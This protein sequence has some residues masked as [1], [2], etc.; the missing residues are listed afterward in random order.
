MSDQYD[1]VVVG[2]GPGGY[3][4]AI[5]AAQYGL[6]TAIVE[7]DLIGGT[8]LN[9]G[10]IPTKA[11]LHMGE[12]L[13]HIN[14]AK[15]VGI[16]VGEPQVDLAK[17]YA[18]K[19]KT[20]KKLRGG[21]SSLLKANKVDVHT[22]TGVLKS[23]GTVLVEADGKSTTLKCKNVILATG[24]KPAVPPIPGLKETA[25]WTSK[26]M[27]ETNPEL[28]KSMIIIGGG[29][30]GAESATILSD[31]GVEVTIVEMMDQLLPRMDAEV[32]EVLR[33]SL[34]KSGVAI[35]LGV[36]VTEVGSKAGK[37][38]CR[39]ETSAGEK[40]VEAEEV[41][42]AVGRRTVVDAAG[43]EAA[44]VKLDRGRV[45]VDEKMRTNLAGVYAIG[46]VTG[47]WW[48]A[49]AASAEGLA[50]VD[51]I[52][53]KANYTNRSVMPACVY[54]R[55]E[56]AAVGAT[57]EEAKSSGRDVRVGRFPISVNSKSMI[58]G[59]TQGFVKI[60]A[61]HE[62]GE[63]LG[64]HLVGPRATDMISEIA[65]AMSAELTI[66]ELGAVIH[67]HPTVS[68]AMMEA[69]HDIEGLCVHKP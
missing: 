49:H 26:T 32:A 31:L 7:R 28:P 20:V 24:S 14:D 27:L 3:V 67:P 48:L 60:I 36:K 19:D 43:I 18:Y 9:R 56:I 45:V 21:V 5:R 52:A 46:D 61:D 42:V 34:T 58:M 25:Y 65:T 54:T 11:M 13:H 40:S 50:A 66:E 55:P 39:I 63:I 41:M 59:E 62:T 69:V 12:T 51:D 15:S 16:T 4:A 2:S 23:A 35:E 57:E 10:C 53:G 29:V 6:K 8:C 33:K 1:V 64:A 68:E 44:G 37:K 17:L 47:T 38:F 30:I 22:G